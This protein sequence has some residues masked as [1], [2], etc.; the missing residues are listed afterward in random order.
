MQ[1]NSQEEKPER[2]VAN[3]EEE[4]NC[5][6]DKL[7]D[8]LGD[9]HLLLRA[10]PPTLCLLVTVDWTNFGQPFFNLSFLVVDV[11]L[12]KGC[13]EGEEK[14]EDQPDVNVLQVV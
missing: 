5:R 10:Q 9:L 14:V 12:Q 4:A 2:P 1:S 3:N 11:N 7:S 6:V 8:E 13:D